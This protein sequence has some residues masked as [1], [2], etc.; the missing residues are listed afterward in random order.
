MK[1]SISKLLFILVLINII[2]CNNNQEKPSKTEQLELI[3]DSINKNTIEFISWDMSS[4]L[5]EEY[6]SKIKAN[7]EKTDSLLLKFLVESNFMEDGANEQLYSL[8]YNKELNEILSVDE[9]KL[10]KTSKKFIKNAEKS[11]FNI[12]GEEGNLYLNLKSSYLKEGIID[13]LDSLSK[14]YLNLYSYEIDNRCCSD[15]AF[16][17]SKSEIANRIYQWGE[18]ANKVKDKAYFRFAKGYFDSYLD[19]LYVGLD[20]S[21]AFGWDNGEF[22]QESLEAMEIL[23][24][25]YPQS[26]AAKEF[27]TF[28]GLLKESNMKKSK[29][30]EEY[31]ADRFE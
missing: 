15:G 4:K 29:E 17:I 7:P 21:P 19:Y 14:E 10:S 12:V 18:L 24:S 6:I 27:N 30:I 5:K 26:L 2:S 3:N 13:N 11:G 22:D 8:D 25:N 28:M 16:V 1:I 23:I 20:N 9:D 31:I